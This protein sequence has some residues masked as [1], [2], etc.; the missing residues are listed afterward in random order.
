MAG[1]SDTRQL[2]ID[3]LMGRPAGTEIQPEDHQAF[4]LALNDYI[5]S[6]E[7]VAGSGV[8]VAFAE[9]D[10]VPIQPNNG[11][12]VY[13]SYVPRSTTKNFVNFINQS[14]N[15]I[16]ITS[17][18][19]EVKLVTLLWNGSYWS[20]QIVTINVI[21]D[22]SS[23]NASNIGA[24]DYISFS[25]NSNY[26]I[27]YIVRYDG[28]LYKFIAEHVA[29]A[30]T[31]DDVEP[32]SI[33]SIIASEVVIH[34]TKFERSPFIEKAG[35]WV[36]NTV[37][38][39][40]ATKDANGTIIY[41]EKNRNQLYLWQNELYE[42]NEN[43]TAL[44]KIDNQTKANLLY[45]NW[46][47]SNVCEFTNSTFY[48]STGETTDSETRIFSSY[49]PLGMFY[50]KEGYKIAA[51][52]YYN[53]ETL[54]YDSAVQSI[55]AQ[56]YNLDK[57]GCVARV[58][59]IKDDGA[60]FTP[61][62]YL[63]GNILN[64][65]FNNKI[66]S[67]NKEIDE[68]QETISFP[69][70]LIQA[71]QYNNGSI[72]AG[73]S[74]RLLTDLFSNTGVITA[75]EGWQLLSVA[76]FNAETLEFDSYKVL[77]N[78]LSAT[79]GKDGCLARLEIAKIGN[80]DCTP[81]DYYAGNFINTYYND[82]IKEI[83]ADVASIQKAFIQTEQVIPMKFGK[84]SSGR[85]NI[86]SGTALYDDFFNHLHS[87]LYSV[88]KVSELNPAQERVDILM[89]SQQVIRTSKVNDLDSAASIGDEVV[90][91]PST[92]VGWL[93]AQIPVKAG[94]TYVVSG[95]ASGG[96]LPLVAVVNSLNV[97]VQKVNASASVTTA[98]VNIEEDGQMIIN[99]IIGFPLFAYQL[100]TPELQYH[101][102]DNQYSYLG[103]FGI[104]I[105][106][107]AK[108]VRLSSTSDIPYETEHSVILPYIGT[109]TKSKESFDSLSVV[110][111]YYPVY[112]HN[113]NA[114]NEAE[115]TLQDSA[116]LTYDQIKFILPQNY[117]PSGDP[118]RLVIYV[119]GSGGS[120][121]SDRSF[122]GSGAQSRATYVAQEGYAVMMINGITAKYHALYPDVNDNFATPTGMTCYMY[123]YEW[124]INN[125]NIKTDGVFVYGKSLGGV[126]V[127]NILHSKLPVLAAAGLAPV[128]D[129]ISE[130][131]R[132]RD[133][134]TKRFYAD[135]FSMVGDITFSDRPV[136][137]ANRLLENAFFKANAH[138]A[139]GY[140][141]IWNG[142]IGLDVEALLTE[143]YKY[144]VI[145]T[146]SELPEER[147]L[148]ESLPHY[149]P[150]PLKIWIAKDDVNVDPRFCDYMQKMCQKGGSLYRLR[151]MPENTGRHWAV[152]S[153]S[154][155]DGVFQEPVRATIKPRYYSEEITQAVA[156]IE[157]VS[158]FRRFES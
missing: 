65:Y 93:S 126:G 24:S 124:M 158:W 27:G 135:Q 84:L 155:V 133:A 150:A 107:D 29:G 5:R 73:T 56:S 97:L 1:Y 67:F 106:K 15:S 120:I 127:G 12:A 34:L 101:Y 100:F 99:Q 64:R 153:G 28:K 17:S 137:A 62:D 95:L 46:L 88:D 61:E 157:M 60:E 145:Q 81:A 91:T 86:P 51:V 13:L 119:Q 134:Q 113:Q 80:S 116:E 23:V 156:F 105:P 112:L 143:T 83:Q 118:V 146:G 130:V 141:P 149:L 117:N 79:I 103:E 123:A 89:T 147:A 58:L 148:Y 20:S 122:N 154:E 72:N 132:N 59:I 49:I 111:A 53:A 50:A 104:D 3:T 114:D 41:R 82:K 71:S 92:A 125:F 25:P 40:I 98:T 14:G 102:Y 7:L 121:W 69:F 87:T 39:A 54:A 152:D 47:L 68:L 35:D 140:N 131:M 94:E 142:T 11:Q 129:C 76:Y 8:P 70:T 110:L 21:S 22:D 9:P 138:K 26:P 6:V 37:N 78:A 74:N 115:D 44:V 52:A 109:M 38:Y 77:N 63:N 31:G 96:R 75:K 85:I 48:P 10:T 139:I 18:S 57:A 19:G 66:D 4:A 108:Y 144:P 16:S 2:I 151:W 55:S 33:N 128:L 30:W 36:C 43:L 136:S 32:A 45:N 90:I 42:W